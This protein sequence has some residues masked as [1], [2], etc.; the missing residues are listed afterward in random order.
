MR[1]QAEAIIAT[2]PQACTEEERVGRLPLDP[3]KL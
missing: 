3:A 2:F 1:A